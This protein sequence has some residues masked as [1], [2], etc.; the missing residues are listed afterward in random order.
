MTEVELWAQSFTD[1][2]QGLTS[3]VCVCV[4]VCV[5]M[6]VCV[7]VCVVVLK[8]HGNRDIYRSS[9]CPAVL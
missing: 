2:V 9:A 4:C 8:W 1:R 3:E 6:C 5:C 7:C